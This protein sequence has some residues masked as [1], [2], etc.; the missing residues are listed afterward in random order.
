MTKFK[1]DEFAKDLLRTIL[2]PY[3]KVQIDRPITNELR[4]IDVFFTP[5]GKAPQ[6]PTLQ[7]LWKCATKGASFEPFRS[8]VRDWE[9]RSTMGKLF[10]V[11]GELT[12]A[13][14]RE[15]KPE[16]KTE[17]LPQLW[18]ITPT[19]SE[20][21][22]KLANVIK[23][24]DWCDGI[25]FMGDMVRTG[26]IV[27]HKL[28]KT[29]ETVWFRILG[30][31]KVQEE[32]IN[33]IAALFQNSAYRQKILELFAGLKVNLEAST[34]RDLEEMELL[35]SLTESP[36][37]IEYMERATADALA[38]GMTTGVKTGYQSVVESMIVDR[39]GSVDEELSAILPNV[40]KLS[41]SEFTPL[42]MHLS[43]TELIARFT[44]HS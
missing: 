41:P 39:F 32:A 4:R 38:Q 26:I 9:V 34:E 1:H 3:G 29:P 20:E 2:E 23:K 6:D 19:M 14:H 35:M 10:D 5:V 27:V 37:F 44:D 7:L 30:R 8:P 33:E 12:R 25:Y 21:K 13:A 31:G 17:E 42:L 18:I 15:K 22:L 24:E 11:H 43:R 40:L 28:P 16:P 36:V